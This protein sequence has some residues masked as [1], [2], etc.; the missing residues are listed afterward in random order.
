MQLRAFLAALAPVAAR[1][2]QVF[3][4]AC[5]AT[6]EIRGGEGERCPAASEMPQGCVPMLARTSAA[7]H[8]ASLCPRHV[9]FI[10]SWAS[11]ALVTRMLCCLR[12]LQTL[13]A[14]QSAVRRWC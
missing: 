9:M 12:K 14:W 1:Q 11:C 7:R 2:P 6:V 4:E 5:R 13:A 8:L 10:A 3:V